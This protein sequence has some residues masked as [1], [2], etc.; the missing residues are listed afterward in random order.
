VES[1]TAESVFN[2]FYDFLQFESHNIKL[3][4]LE[5]NN[6]F[7]IVFQK[8]VESRKSERSEKPE[9]CRLIIR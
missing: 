7:Y 5:V 8:Y 4:D 2:E 6:P 9:K 3:V 1:E